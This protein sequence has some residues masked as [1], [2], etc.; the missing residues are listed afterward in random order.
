M[1]KASERSPSCGETN[2]LN[3]TGIRSNTP[4]TDCSDT[5]TFAIISITRRPFPPAVSYPG[6]R[7]EYAGCSKKDHNIPGFSIT[8]IAEPPAS[9]LPN[10]LAKASPVSIIWRTI[11][12]SVTPITDMPPLTF[13]IFSFL[14]S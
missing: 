2:P 13:E 11:Y 1:P 6:W 3:M 10:T 4:D 12:S 7:K 9:S 8:S 5:D 14:I